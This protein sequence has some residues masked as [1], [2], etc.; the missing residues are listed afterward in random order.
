L[1]SNVR[2]HALIL[3]GLLAALV[4]SGV[5]CG[6]DNAQI[7]CERLDACGCLTE[8]VEACQ[9]R[10][11]DQDED[12]LEL[13]GHCLSTNDDYMCHELTASHGACRGCTD[14]FASS[15]KAR[16]LKQ[17]GSAAGV[18]VETTCVDVTPDAGTP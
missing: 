13:C 2:T 10:I 7:V 16:D 3:S 1:V 8:S 12:Q 5:G 9:D 18:E 17:T 6:D 14:A 11:D 15:D 4:G